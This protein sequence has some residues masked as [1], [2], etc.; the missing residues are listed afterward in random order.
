M[1]S[2]S[3]ARRDLA[4]VDLVQGLAVALVP[5]RF[6]TMAGNCTLTAHPAPST[7]GAFAPGTSA[8]GGSSRGRCSG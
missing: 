5:G 7:R 4:A 6:V 1:E 8:T 3:N 2:F